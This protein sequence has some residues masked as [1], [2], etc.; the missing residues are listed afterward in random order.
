MIFKVFSNLSHSVIILFMH[1][2]AVKQGP[3]FPKESENRGKL[4][5]QRGIPSDLQ[6]TRK[7]SFSKERGKLGP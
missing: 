6:P 4:L 2:H 5:P 3:R 1:S 7:L